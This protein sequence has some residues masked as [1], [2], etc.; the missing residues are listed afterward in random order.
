MALN[1][2]FLVDRR[3]LKRRLSVWRLGA[4]VAVLG[5]IAALAFQN[6]DIAAAS[7]FKPQIARVSISGII[8]DDRKQQTLL[9]DVGEASQVKAV[10]LRIN[11][12][13]G[14]ATGGESLFEAVRALAKKKPVVAVFGTIATSSAYMVGLASDH[15]VA[16]GN[17]ITGSVGVILQWAEV[18]ELLKNIGVKMEE[19]RSGPL[20]AKPSPFQ[21][22]DEPTRQLTEEMVSEAH[23]WFLDLVAKRRSITPVD[24]PGLAEG[25]IYSGRRALEL[26]LID[27][28]GGENEA[29]AWLEEKRQIP[30]DLTIIDWETNEGGGIG[31][32]GAAFRTLAGIAG[33]PASGLNILFPPTEV[34]RAVQLDGF[35]SLWHPSRD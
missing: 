25:R 6:E 34:L 10:I 30:P 4:I 33:V 20:K 1:A 29:V 8:Q 24:V 23:K 7:G 14:T 3:R 2:E 31:L 22:L 16:R 18:T 19:I 21:P 32:W 12:P 9:F 35:V 17:S 13:G 15:I 28:I 5:L 11:S 27:Q 26:E